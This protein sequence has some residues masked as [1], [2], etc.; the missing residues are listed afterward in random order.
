MKYISTIIPVFEVDREAWMDEA[1]CTENPNLWH[2]EDKN[3]LAL[4]RLRCQTCP[5]M[6]QCL[7]YALDY[8]ARTGHSH[9]VWGGAS[10]RERRKLLK[11][12]RSAA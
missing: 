8:E 5:V 12:R 4:A 1:I 3:M 11:M 9:G 10:T 2:D 7:E 6:N